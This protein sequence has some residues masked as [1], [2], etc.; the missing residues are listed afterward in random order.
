MKGT[1]VPTGGEVVIACMHTID[2]SK[3]PRA[4]PGAT[5]AKRSRFKLTALRNIL[6][7]AH[8][9]SRGQ[10]GD[11]VLVAGDTN[12]QKDEVAEAVIGRCGEKVVFCGA[13]RDF[14]FSKHDLD[15]KRIRATMPVAHDGMHTAVATTVRLPGEQVHLFACPVGLRESH[16]LMPSHRL[17]HAAP[18]GNMGSLV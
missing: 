3:K 12:L 2:G 17:A 6:D 13:K 16:R 14:I 1:F 5:A 15:T 9:A 10:E 7:M 18:L 11:M 4:V 8:A